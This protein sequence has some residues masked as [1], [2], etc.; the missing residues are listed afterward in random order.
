MIFSKFMEFQLSSSFKTF[1]A[2][3]KSPHDHLLLIFTAI[4]TSAQATTSLLSFPI[5]VPF[6]DNS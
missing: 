4:P 2:P 5:D 6:L 3:P 1:S